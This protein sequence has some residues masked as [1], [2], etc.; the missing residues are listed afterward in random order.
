MVGTPDRKRLWL[1][2][3]EP[4]VDDATYQ[5]RVEVAAANGFRVEGLRRLAQGER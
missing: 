4:H 3:R 5:R 1:L 2:A